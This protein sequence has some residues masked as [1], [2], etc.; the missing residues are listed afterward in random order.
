MIIGGIDQEEASTLKRKAEREEANLKRM[1]K[2]NT[3]ESKGQANSAK[4]AKDDT[5]LSDSAVVDEYIPE[6]VKTKPKKDR[7]ISHCQKN[8]NLS[9]F[10]R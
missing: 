5:D 7:Q 10:T 6:S 2:Q 9:A 3:N 1:K 8:Y 4:S